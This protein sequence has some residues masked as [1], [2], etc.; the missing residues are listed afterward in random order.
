M[1]EGED[2]TDLIPIDWSS[3]QD[4]TP[5]RI[6]LGVDH[7]QEQIDN[8][9]STANVK[10]FVDHTEVS[11]QVNIKQS[12]VNKDKNSKTTNTRTNRTNHNAQSKRENSERNSLAS[13]ERQQKV[14]N[15]NVPFVVSKRLCNHWMNITKEVPGSECNKTLVC[16]I[17]CT[18]VST[19]VSTLW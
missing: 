14:A 6:R 1:G 13:R 17:P 16:L 11:K 10:D 2:S 19:R 3:I 4:V 7:V 8:F 5:V 15:L 9:R 12:V 18:A